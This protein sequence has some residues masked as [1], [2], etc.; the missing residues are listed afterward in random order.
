MK[1]CKKC[2]KPYPDDAEFC[3]NCGEK[4]AEFGE[5][6]KDLP[7]NPKFPKFNWKIIGSII[8]ILVIIGAGYWIWIYTG[9]FLNP[10]RETTTTTTTTTYEPE[11]VC[12]KP[13]MRI[14]K[15]CCLDAN[16]NGVCDEDEIKQDCP[17]EC[18]VDENYK[19]KQCSYDE[20][21]ID[22]LCV[23]K[24]CPYECCIY[25]YEVKE[26]T[27]NED[28]INNRCVKKD[29]PYECCD[30]TIYQAKSCSSGYECV[31][32]KCEE[33]KM[34][35]LML[36]IDACDTGLNIM[37]GRGEVTD[38]Y[39][40]VTNYGTKEAIGVQIISTANDIQREYIK[41]SGTIASLPVDYSQKF[42]VTVDTRSNVTT[43]VS[44]TV[45]C[46]ECSPKSVTETHSDCHVDW[47]FWE[48]KAQEYIELGGK[49]ISPF[50]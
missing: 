17:Y 20:D 21:C 7:I 31:N 25:E 13:Y 48:Q 33:I 32:N 49:I 41:S 1:Y 38:V 42:K 30:G 12:N 37:E 44:V 39:A 26:C 14:G 22:N 45:S 34:P 10:D 46:D 28:C 47:E 8:V 11:I 16:D 5:K 18:C 6:K 50:G 15:E 4:I 27:Y 9:Q 2:D 43:V 29:C 35:K 40:T 3:S 24:D 36:K 23:K 19:P